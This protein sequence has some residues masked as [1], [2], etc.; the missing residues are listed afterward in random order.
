MPDDHE[1]NSQM[2]I[3]SEDIENLG[4]HSFDR[5]NREAEERGNRGN[6]N[7]RHEDE[8]EQG[9]DY[10]RETRAQGEQET[11]TRRE[12][13][14]EPEQEGIR[15]SRRARSEPEEHED[16]EAR[17]LRKKTKADVRKYKRSDAE[18]FLESI[19]TLTPA[20]QMV[21]EQVRNYAADIKESL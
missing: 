18:S 16:V 20:H 9:G 8:R 10:N 5:E 7:Q 11:H 2:Q 19:F 3:L 21:R 13:P 14:L 12:A 15:G 4:K 6:S 1:S 17:S